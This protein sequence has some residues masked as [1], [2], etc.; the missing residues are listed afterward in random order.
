MAQEA[1]AAIPNKSVVWGAGLLLL[2]MAWGFGVLR[3]DDQQLM[4]AAAQW[5][6]AL[7]AG[8]LSTLVLLAYF[9]LRRRPAHLPPTSAANWLV[10]VPLLFIY[11]LLSF[12][13]MAICL[14]MG[15]NMRL[16]TAPLQEVALPVERRNVPAGQPNDW[17]VVVSFEGQHP[18]IALPG[19]PMA[20]A[21]RTLR[22]TLQRGWLGYWVIRARQPG[23]LDLPGKA[24]K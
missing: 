9:R 14:A 17:Y 21:A 23:I 8:L 2:S 16:A 22:L 6:L 1:S 13:P 4:P 24:G 3:L 20:I 15:L 19:H 7:G 10:T 18:R 12:G 11:C 5:Q